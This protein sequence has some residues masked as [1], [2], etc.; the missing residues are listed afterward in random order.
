[1]KDEQ[2]QKSRPHVPVKGRKSADQQ[3]G[4]DNRHSFLCQG[5][6]GARPNDDE[7]DCGGEENNRERLGGGDEGQER[8]G[9]NKKNEKRILRKI[10]LKGA[11]SFAWSNS[12][13]GNKGGDFDDERL[14]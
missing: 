4:V 13:E 6:W 7:I 5:R 14:D 3:E 10:A 12:K 9:K 11:Q 2:N 8:G 1:V